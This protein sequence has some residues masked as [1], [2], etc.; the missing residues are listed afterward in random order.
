MP[1]SSTPSIALFLF[2][3]QDDEFAVY[4][5]IEECMRKGLLP[6]CLYFTS[7]NYGGQPSHIRSKE[8]LAALEQLGV[9]TNQIFF[10]GEEK[11]ISD[12]ELHLHFDLALS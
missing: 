5:V 7:G 11:A 1:S 12:G 9:H 2:A 6:I 10:L 3:H 4:S 8:S